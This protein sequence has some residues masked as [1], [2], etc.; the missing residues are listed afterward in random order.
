[1]RLLRKVLKFM[2]LAAVLLFVGAQFVRPEK[3]NRPV[4]P[5]RTLEA[6]AQVPPEVSAILSR[7]CN[8]C[9]SNQTRWP[10]YSQIAPASWFLADHVRDGR[11]M[12]NFSNWS[13]YSRSDAASL[14]GL[15]CREVQT[16]TMPLP[17]YT[18]IHRD[19]RLSEADVRTLCD[20]SQ[21][22]RERLGKR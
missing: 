16:G 15:V 17:S 22:E 10:W 14:L 3:I 18:I 8:D 1:M 19:A 12:L 13:R 7:S 4:D 20:W 5:A 9:H 2:A 21:A 6:N 11:R